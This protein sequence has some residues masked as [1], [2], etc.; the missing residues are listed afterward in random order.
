[1]YKRFVKGSIIMMRD[2]NIN[3]SQEMLL[4]IDDINI[5]GMEYYELI[6]LLENL[7]NDDKVK[8]FNRIVEIN[9][10]IW[11]VKYECE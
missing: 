9:K 11:G 1:M 6:E 10:I 8:L 7:S 4:N 5:Y 2:D 3:E